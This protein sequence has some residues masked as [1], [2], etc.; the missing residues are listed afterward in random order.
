MGFASLDG[1]EGALVMRDSD[2]GRHL[3]AR[4]RWRYSFGQRRLQISSVVPGLATTG[5]GI[6]P[7]SRVLG[8]VSSLLLRA[9]SQLTALPVNADIRPMIAVSVLS[10]TC[11]SSLRGRPSWML[12][13]MSMCSW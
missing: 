1:L 9:C 5:P 4:G 10:A 8:N 7:H 6:G 2:P 3:G 13:S 12:A 11:F